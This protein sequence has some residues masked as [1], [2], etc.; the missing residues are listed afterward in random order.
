MLGAPF[1]VAPVSRSADRHPDYLRSLADADVEAAA[2]TADAADP[3][4][5]RAAVDAVRHRFGRI[6]VATTARPPSD[7][8]PMTSPSS[9]PR[10]PKPH[11]AVPWPPSTSHRCCFPN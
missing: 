10:A 4:A 9:T 8:L 3:V 2:F 6:D 1:A 7:R 5:L 11:C